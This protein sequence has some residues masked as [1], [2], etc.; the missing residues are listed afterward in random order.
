MQGPHNK[1][2]DYSCVIFE[3]WF[4]EIAGF[5]KP[6]LQTSMQL[7]VTVDKNHKPFWCQ[8]KLLINSSSGVYCIQSQ[9]C[10]GTNARHRK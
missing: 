8:Q 10:G 2:H 3:L 4:S 7:C 5:S 1:Q 9:A 6:V